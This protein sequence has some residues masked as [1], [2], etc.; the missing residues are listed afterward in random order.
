MHFPS[1]FRNTF[2]QWGPVILKLDRKNKKMGKSFILGDEHGKREEER[3]E[4]I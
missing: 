4:S 1:Y 2:L 3:K